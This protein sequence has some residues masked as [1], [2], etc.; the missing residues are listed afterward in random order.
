MPAKKKTPLVLVILDGWGLTKVKKGNAIF[1][2]RTPNMDHFYRSYPSS[3]LIASGRA[4]GLPEG[5]MG[6]SEVGHLNL[7]AGRLVW[8]DMLRI[9]GAIEDGSFFDNDV[10]RQAMLKART[11]ASGLHLIGLLSDG[12]VHSHNTHLYAL[13]QLAKRMGVTKVYIHAILD[14]RDVPPTSAAEYLTALEAKMAELGIGSLASLAGRYYAMDRDRHWNR[15]RRAY[16]AYV[17]G[18]A[19]RA[20]NALEAIDA[21]YKRGETDEFVLPTLITGG[22]GGSPVLITSEDVLLFFNFRSDRARQISRSFLE[23]EFVYFDR[24]LNPVFPYIVCLTEYAPLLAAP[25]AF[26]PEYLDDTL[27]EVISKCGLRQLRIAETEKYAHVTYFFNGGRE[28]PF[29]GEERILVPSP[30][31]AT[32]DLAP[33]MSASQ[34]TA[35]ALKAL[36]DNT[37]DLLV[38]NYANADMVG[39]TGNL[40]A[41]IEAVEAVDFELG[42]LIGKILEKKGVALITAD[43]GNAE[44]MFGKNGTPQTAHTNND[45]PLILVAAENQNR[46]G[47]APQGSLADVAPTILQL[48][49]LPVPQAMSGRS[50]LISRTDG[51]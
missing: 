49:A 11:G 31:V 30:P 22:D 26:P 29:P 32:Y 41:A 39:H 46:Y 13:L 18:D 47:L 4:V 2:A 9:S 51:S 48:L 37:Y 38:L 16:S 25:S 24:G 35:A 12:G 23:Q 50:M 33:K 1:L 19:L 45:T 3:R 21:A 34:V 7:G 43:H 5:Q 40:A 20:E 8:Q 28:E 44:K 42:M 17:Y 15:T 36:E 14:G 6:N 27:G 10:L